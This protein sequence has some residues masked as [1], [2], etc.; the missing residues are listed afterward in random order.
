[1]QRI[2][3]RTGVAWAE[4]TWDG[5]VP[6][7][8]NAAARSAQLVELRVPGVRV[9]RATIDHPV[10]GRCAPIT[11][12]HGEL[13]T[14]ISAIDWA[15]PTEIPAI[16]APGRLP[17]GAGGVILNVLALLAGSRALRYAGPYPTSALYHS[18]LRSF[19]TEATEAE[20]TAGGVDRALRGARDVLPFAFVPAPHERVA[21]PRGHA[22]LRDGLERVVIDGVAYARGGSPAR[23]V[24]GRAEIWFGDAPWAEVATFAADGALLE[25]PHPLP[26]CTS[27]VIGKEFPAPLREAIAELV[28]EAVPA[29]LAAAAAALV[30]RGPIRW[31]DLGARAARRAPDGLE[32]HA[33]LWDRLAPSGL[34]RVAL[35]LAEALAPVVATAVVAEAGVALARSNSNPV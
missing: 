15:A 6:N 25:G 23:L 7:A 22:E 5:P 18:L 10:L 35:A 1:M 30:A 24:E 34:A 31:A 12:D 20:F 26:A 28:A 2:T 27:D 16:A 8:Y 32:L 14:V 29:P 33:A 19:R 21:F 11:S 3:D 17:A 13:L 4:L 9:G